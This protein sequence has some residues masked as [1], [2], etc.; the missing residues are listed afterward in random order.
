MSNLIVE[1]NEN[2]VLC[3][4]GGTIN[5]HSG[6]VKFRNIVLQFKDAYK[7]ARSRFDKTM[8]SD[9]VVKSIRSMNPPG[10]FLAEEYGSWVDIGD[11]KARSKVSQAL[12]EKKVYKQYH[13]QGQGSKEENMQVQPQPQ[14][15]ASLAQNDSWDA[16][17][18]FVSESPSTS[19]SPLSNEEEP[20]EPDQ[21]SSFDSWDQGLEPDP[22]VQV[23]VP[24]VNTHLQQRFNNPKR[25]LFHQ[26]QEEETCLVPML[27]SGES[28][29]LQDDNDDEL[30]RE[31]LKSIGSLESMRSLELSSLEEMPSLRKQTEKLTGVVGVTTRTRPSQDEI[32]LTKHAF[33]F[34]NSYVRCPIDT[35]MDSVDQLIYD[36]FM[37][38]ISSSDVYNDKNRFVDK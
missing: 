23:H 13:H 38:S 30:M 19:E 31:S 7:Q 17:P 32:D 25:A 24:H 28:V 2:D 22:F 36:T 10:R 8:I 29:N 20:P 27:C 34:S 14:P 5:S 18:V 37:S 15:Q 21:M 16:A 4:R 3:G 26:R 1:I 11:D 6:N 9:T 35:K 12:R 33:S